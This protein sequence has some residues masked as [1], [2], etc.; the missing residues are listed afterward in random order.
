MGNRATSKVAY[1]S[2]IYKKKTT[3][4]ACNMLYVADT[5]SSHQIEN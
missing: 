3:Q 2:N 1:F 5:S 4:L